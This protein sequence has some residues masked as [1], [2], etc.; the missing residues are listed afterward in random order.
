NGAG[1]H[2][3]DVANNTTHTGSSSLERF[4]RA[5]GIVRLNFECNRQA[6]TYINNAGVF[7]AGPDEDFWRFRG[8]A[9]QQ[10]PAVLVGA[11]LAPHD[12]EDPQLGIGWCPAE[13]ALQLFVLLW[14]EVMFPHQF[15]CNNWICNN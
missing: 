2:R 14:R 5:G 6:I 11:V 10:R 9:A 15:R 1:A 13:Y 8:K 12:R 3:K 4:D 7:L